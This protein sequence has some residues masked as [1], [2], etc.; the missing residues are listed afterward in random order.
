[1]TRTVAILI[2]AAIV[3]A[4]ALSALWRVPFIFTLLG[5]AALVLGGIHS[6]ESP[7]WLH[8]SSSCLSRTA[9]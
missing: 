9:C 4:V 7:C 5:I 2:V 3:V 8:G 1:M 6:Q